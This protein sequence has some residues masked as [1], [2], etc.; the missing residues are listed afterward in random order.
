M[1]LVRCPECG[2]EVSS[3]ATTCPGC[4]CPI[5]PPLPRPAAVVRHGGA[6]EIIG[7]FVIV[8]GLLSC[9]GI[10]A[11]GIFIIFAGLGIFIAGRC[12]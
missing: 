8:G 1:A 12:M 10:G 11:Y 9:F 7:S 5:S 3:A 2:R 6:Y 4:A